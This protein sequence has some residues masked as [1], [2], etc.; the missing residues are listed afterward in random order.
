MTYQHLGRE[1]RRL[2]ATVADLE[3]PRQKAFLVGV[4][5]GRNSA[6]EVEQSLE[7]LALLTDT[8]GSEPVDREV[9]NR[10]APDP[11]LFIGKGQAASLADITNAEDIDVVVFDNALTPAQQR[12]LQGLFECDVVDRE[13]VILDIFAQHASS[14]EG[15]LQVELALLRY[16]LP[17][18]RGKGEVLS[19]QAGGIGTRAS[20]L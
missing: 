20:G 14:R 16:R 8:A 3:V 19:Q 15:A 12:N 2:T 4:R 6:L 9:F 1:R 7:E 18:L 11:G 5:L 13:A 10:S 17:R